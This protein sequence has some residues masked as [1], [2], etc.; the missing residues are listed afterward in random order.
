MN[1]Q[2]RTGTS[3]RPVKCVGITDIERQMIFG[4]RV[5]LGPAYAVKTLGGLPVPFLELGS[6]F[7]GPLA[8]LIG[9][10]QRKPP[11]IL[12]LPYL[13]NIF[14][15]VN[16]EAGSE[17]LPSSPWLSFSGQ[18]L[19][20]SAPPLWE[21]RC[22]CRPGTMTSKTAHATIPATLRALANSLQALN[23]LLN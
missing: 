6:E 13:K 20:G 11:G 9:L 8:D 16:S 5:H 15:L 2:M 21:R 7:S 3:V 18:A 10:K 1:H 12:L 14:T 4:I 23:K 19:A 22:L 17:M